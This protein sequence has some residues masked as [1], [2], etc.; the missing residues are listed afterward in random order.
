MMAIATLALGL[1]VHVCPVLRAGR[2]LRPALMDRTPDRSE[3]TARCSTFPRSWPSPPSVYLGLRHD[4]A[5]DGSDTLH[6]SLRASAGEDPPRGIAFQ[7][8]AAPDPG[9]SPCPSRPRFPIGRLDGPRPS[10]SRATGPAEGLDA[11]P[12]LL[13]PPDRQARV[14]ARMDWKSLRLRDARPSTLALFLAR[15]RP[16]LFPAGTCRSTRTAKGS[17]A[18]SIGY[19]DASGSLKHDGADTAVIFNT[20]CSFVTNTNLQHYSGEQ[21]LTYFSARSARSSSGSMFV[22]PGRRPLR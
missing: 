6:P 7:R 3:S 5:R 9:R 19:K 17:L 15:V 13:C 12:L 1:N 2:G 11:V 14:P 22:T 20:V 10:T 16:S 4:P 18:G 21:N 8:L